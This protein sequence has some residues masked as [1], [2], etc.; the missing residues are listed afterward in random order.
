MLI[1]FQQDNVPIHTSKLTRT[2]FQE[3]DINVL[4]FP[5][6]NLIENA[7]D[8]WSRLVYKDGRQFNSKS[9]FEDTSRTSWNNLE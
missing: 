7:W 1:I 3:R 5:D 8:K 9:E 4:S 2:F 6:L